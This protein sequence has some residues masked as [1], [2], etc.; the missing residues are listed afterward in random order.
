MKVLNFPS[1]PTLVLSSERTAPHPPAG[2]GTWSDAR[3][4]GW[5]S[6][7]LVGFWAVAVA[8]L[9]LA[10]GDGGVL[11]SKTQVPDL[12]AQRLFN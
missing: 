5:F 1:A 7:R 8:G 3:G 10:P 12:A 2:F 4:A 6:W 9:L 11:F